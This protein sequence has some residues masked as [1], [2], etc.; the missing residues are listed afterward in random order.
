M[1]QASQSKKAHDRRLTFLVNTIREI[2]FEATADGTIVY[3]NQSWYD[4]VGKPEGVDIGSAWRKAI[5]PDDVKAAVKAWHH[6]VKTGEPLEAEYRIKQAATGEYNWFVARAHPYHDGHNKIARWYGTCVNIE[7]QKRNDLLMEMNHAKDEFISIAS[8]Q[9]RT[10]A[11]AVKQYIGMLQEGFAGELDDKQLQLLK[12]AYESNERQLRIVTDLLRVAQVDA[13][14]VIINKEPCDVNK[15]VHKI[16]Q[17]HIGSFAKRDQT[18]TFKD[19][20]QPAIAQ[21]DGDLVTMVIDNL[22]DNASKYTE[23][24]GSVDVVVKGDDNSVVVKVM[25]QGVGISPDD[26]PRLF[27]KFTRIDNVLSTTVG[28]TGLGLYWAKKV[29][30][31][32]GGTLSYSPNAPK[33]SVFTV[34]LPK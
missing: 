26:E 17:A 4:Y 31:L 29:I 25:D 2:V 3:A 1:L 18:L 16:T 33:G 20:I 32:H 21:L 8:H 13:G 5:H 19:S 24:G 9:L 6:T 15:L 7:V 28:G 23:E 27:T 11:T 34:L 10:P 12:K 30:D 22:I 14:K